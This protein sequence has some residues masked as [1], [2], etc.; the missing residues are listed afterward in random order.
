MTQFFA[1]LS[2]FA[3][4]LLLGMIITTTS[5]YGNSIG[6][7]CIYSSFALIN[8]F[9]M[10][11]FN[12]WILAKPNTT[13]K[14]ELSSECYNYFAT[15]NNVGRNINTISFMTF[16]TVYILVSMAANKMFYVLTILMIMFL[17][18]NHYYYYIY[19]LRCVHNFA[20]Y[21]VISFVF[22]LLSSGLVFLMGK[23]FL[24]YNS[25]VYGKTM[26]N[27]KG[28][29]FRCVAYKPASV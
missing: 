17:T 11:S 16:T 19:K 1:Y 28:N 24:L 21:I 23:D 14:S 7:F 12:E 22:G 26:C 20:I 25:S 5:V 27:R 9:I 3:P 2:Y 29:R 15:S 18:G 10:Y 13:I 4:P 8:Q 6:S